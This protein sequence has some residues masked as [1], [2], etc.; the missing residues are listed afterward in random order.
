MKIFNDIA[1]NLNQIQIHWMKSKS[2]EINSKFNWKETWCKLVHNISKI[3][4]LLR[5]FIIVVD[6][7]TSLKIHTI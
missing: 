5:L 1:Y 4:L 6:K 2:I 7:K 3:R